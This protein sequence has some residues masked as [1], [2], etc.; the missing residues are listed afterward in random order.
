MTEILFEIIRDKDCFF[1]ITRHLSDGRKSSRISCTWSGEVDQFKNKFTSINH[2]KKK[3]ILMLEKK[4]K[5]EHDPQFSSKKDYEWL[6][7]ELKNENT[8]RNDTPK[9][10]RRV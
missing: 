8:R 5:E 1:R 2:I 7:N 3:A 6:L 9:A 10:H 4:L